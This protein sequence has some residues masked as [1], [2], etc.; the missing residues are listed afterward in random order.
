MTKTKNKFKTIEI[1]IL[2]CKAD[3][4]KVLDNLSDKSQ[5]HLDKLLK[6]AKA[7]DAV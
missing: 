3:G 4:S 2:E 6:I 5:A 7:L 1:L